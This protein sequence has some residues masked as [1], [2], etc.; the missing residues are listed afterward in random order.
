MSEISQCK[1]DQ[2]FNRFDRLWMK[3]EPTAN[4]DFVTQ[5]YIAVLH[6]LV[7]SL[8]PGVDPQHIQEKRCP[9]K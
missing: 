9:E 7:C 8:F 2:V 5:E 3:N 6:K 4:V 1:F